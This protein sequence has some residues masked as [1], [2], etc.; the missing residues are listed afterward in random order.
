[1]L[2]FAGW[3][4]QANLARV[5]IIRILDEGHVETG[6]VPVVDKYPEIGADKKS[7]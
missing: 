1:V 3:A 4:V 5:V 7:A 2:P 6:Q